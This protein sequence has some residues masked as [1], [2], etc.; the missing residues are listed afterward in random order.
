[1]IINIR[2]FANISNY[3]S[4]FGKWKS[5]RFSQKLDGISEFASA[6]PKELMEYVENCCVL[7]LKSVSDIALSFIWL[8]LVS[9]MR[10]F[11]VRSGRSACCGVEME[12]HSLLN[13]VL[14][15]I[16]LG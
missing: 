15:C 16:T 2:H 11:C 1:M 7:R 6:L 10:T 9:K 5:N 8:V 14:I 4:L 3:Y 13:W 12:Y